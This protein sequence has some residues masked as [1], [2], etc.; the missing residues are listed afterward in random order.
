VNESVVLAPVEKRGES[1]ALP[2]V[3]FA[4]GEIEFA[5]LGDPV[6]EQALSPGDPIFETFRVLRARLDLKRDPSRGRCLGIVS[7]TSGEGATT[8]AL[9]LSLS[10]ARDA[11]FSVLLVEA[12]FRQP[13]VKARL[14]LA[15]GPGLSE[16]LGDSEDRPAPLR[17]VEPTGLFVLPAGDP[18]REAPGLL[19]STR[20]ARLL[21]AARTTFDLVI[22]D[23]PP[24]LPYADTVLFQDLP[25]AFLLTVRARW[26]GRAQVK[27]AAARLKPERVAG[28]LLNDQFEVLRPKRAPASPARRPAR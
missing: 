7:A 12:T 26:A 19:E 14:G 8:V 9:A 11:N 10:L 1:P 15:E 18:G 13:A 21:D 28:L 22:V 23:C 4:L 2:K 27:E 6:L 20:F 3:G 17:R 24:L 5:T 16:W 25:D